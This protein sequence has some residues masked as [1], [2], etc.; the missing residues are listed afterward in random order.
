[1]ESENKNLKR[2]V[3]ELEK[4]NNELEVENLGSISLDQ[5]DT[6]EAQCSSLERE[7]VR[8]RRELDTIRARRNIAFTLSTLLN[9]GIVQIPRIITPVSVTSVVVNFDEILKV[10]TKEDES[11][12]DS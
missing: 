8:L 4:R 3:A 10:L 11:I 12:Y 6:L 7:N 2:K 9:D 1:M 5:Y